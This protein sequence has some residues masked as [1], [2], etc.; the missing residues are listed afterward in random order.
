MKDAPVRHLVE[1]AAYL[2]VKGVVRTLPHT[3]AR[4]AGR[5][6][7][8]L[9]WRL[10]GRHRRIAED[11]LAHALP[12]LGADERRRIVRGAF[13]HFAMAMTDSVSAGRFDL[14]ELCRRLEL[15]GWENLQ[16]AEARSAERAGGGLLALTAH[17]GLWEMAAYPRRH[18]RRPAP[19]G[20]P[21]ARQPLARPRAPVRSRKRFGNELIPH[22][23]VRRMLRRSPRG[24]GWGC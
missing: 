1:Y 15:V 22:G 12:E 20:R 23:A 11:N 13:E 9:A 10:L 5:R 4:S 7:G 14:E 8:A 21:A 24:T 3:A 2:A 18:L 16:A 6:L 19:R 17:L